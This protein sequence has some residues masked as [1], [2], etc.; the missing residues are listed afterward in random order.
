MSHEVTEWLA[1]IKTLKQ[2]LAETQRDRDAANASAANWRHLY[3]TEAQQRRT[4]TKLAEQ[5]IERLKTQIRE[6]QGSSRQGN[7]DAAT[8]EAIQQEVEQ[9]QNIE[10]LQA[11]LKQVLLERDRLIE[12]LKIEQANHAQTRKSLTTVIADT[13][14]KIAKERPTSQEKA[15]ANPV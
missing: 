13:I 11:K 4:E 14:D 5:Q 15:D 1:Q 10:E 2:Q 6:L 3:T 9:M 8:V 12:T 7:D